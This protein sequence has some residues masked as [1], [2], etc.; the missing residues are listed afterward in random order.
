MADGS[1][2]ES[3]WQRIR[4]YQGETFKTITALEFRYVVTGHVVTHDRAKGGISKSAF[5][6]AWDEWPVVGPGVFGKRVRGSAYVWGILN[7]P[8]ISGMH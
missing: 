6:K 3:V 4:H 7:D 2:F 8:R 1:E 5:A